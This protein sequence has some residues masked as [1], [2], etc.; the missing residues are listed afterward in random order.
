VG[1]LVDLW[2][3]GPEVHTSVP[4]PAAIE[5]ARARVGIDKL[6]IRAAPLGLRKTRGDVAIDLSGIAKGYGVDAVAGL[7]ESLGITNYLVEIGGELRAR[8]TNRNAQP[9]R[10]G[11]ENPTVDRR[12]I[13]ETIALSD[14]AMASSGNYRNFFVQDGVS[15]GQTLDPVSGK[16]VQH[17][18]A[19]L[20]VL[21]ANA[22]EAD[23]WATA[24]MV[25][26]FERGRRIAG[27]HELAVMF[28]VA[29]AD[30]FER[31]TTERFNVAIRNK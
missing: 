27:A 14:I 16:P 9:W 30:T 29:V 1:P 31:H 22:M 26:G 25:L 8:G 15:Y 23:A 2:G 19:G 7:I 6:E 13:G 5:A 17:D 4:D 28:I 20:T 12:E 3:F 18:L 10:I 21:H 11:I 24:M